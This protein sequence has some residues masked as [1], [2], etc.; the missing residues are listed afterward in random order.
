MKEIVVKVMPPCISEN[1]EQEYVDRAKRA[2]LSGTL[3]VDCPK[4]KVVEDTPTKVVI[5]YNR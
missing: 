2:Y 3:T 4:A 1:R 5:Q